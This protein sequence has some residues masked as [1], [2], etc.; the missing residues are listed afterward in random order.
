MLTRKQHDLL[1]YIHKS[2]KSDGISPSFDEM[3]DALGLRSKSG[4]H[5]LI[6]ALEERGFIRRLPHRARALEVL[7][8]PESMVSAGGFQPSIVA[9]ITPS[10]IT[11][12]PVVESMENI[13]LP[14]YGRIAAGA[15][16]EALN[17]H[18]ETIDM[19]A[20]MLGVPGNP[21]SALVC[22]M[23]FLRP[24]IDVML[25]LG[26]DRSPPETAVLG[27]DLGANDER[28]DYLRAHLE[29][30]PNGDLR[31]IPFDKQDSSMMSTLSQ[32]G[33]LI[34]RPAHA[35]AAPAGER[36]EIIRL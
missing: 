12:Q 34:V 33:C 23:I 25:G 2:L 9:D 1:L 11:G 6:T 7:K 13:S 4:I 8:L 35:V 28:Q 31:A 24:A 22:G 21:V 32:A 5:R 16:I 19:P 27:G 29:R 10:R 30:G 26:G 3:K 18:T 36:V 20:S 17:G 15:P 14:L